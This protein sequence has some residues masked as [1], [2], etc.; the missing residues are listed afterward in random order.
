MVENDG[1]QIKPCKKEFATNTDISKTDN[2]NKY[3][4]TLDYYSDDEF[5]I[6]NI[7]ISETEVQEVE[8]MYTTI[9]KEDEKLPSV[10]AMK[11]KIISRISEEIASPNAINIDE[12][13]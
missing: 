11:N 8:V 4:A 3:K 10:I 13:N 6:D 12:T 5:E 2:L 1:K 9:F 7:D